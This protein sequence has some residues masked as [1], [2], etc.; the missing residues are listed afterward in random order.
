[1][2]HKFIEQVFDRIVV[3]AAAH[4]EDE[5]GRRDIQFAFLR[6]TFV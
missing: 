2:Y 3:T 4:I 6:D 5:I 1:M